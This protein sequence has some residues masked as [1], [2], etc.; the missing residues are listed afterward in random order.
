MFAAM[1]ERCQMRRGCVSE[2]DDG[3]T[4]NVSREIQN[5]Q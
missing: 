4:W 1:S 2:Q 3:E 5:D